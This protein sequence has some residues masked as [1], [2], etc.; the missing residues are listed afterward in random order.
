MKVD[1]EKL[2]LGCFDQPVRGWLN[3]D[4]TPHIWVARVPGL[5]RLMNRVGRLSDHRLAQHQAG[6][7]RSVKYLDLSRRFRLPDA[8]ISAIFSAHMLEHLPP[9]VAANCI[10]ECYRVLRPGGV[11]RTGVPDLDTLVSRY[12]PADPDPVVDAIFETQR[13]GG[14]NRHYWMYNERSLSR[15]MM[16]AGFQ[17][18][19]R[20]GYREGQCPDLELLDNR[21]GETLFIEAIK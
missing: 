1:G 12:D 9:E 17:S 2:H 3:T 20:R 18:T 11:M 16:D 21:P 19:E 5:A 10:R 14:K 13:N 6:V 4:I 8:S 15:A 7:F